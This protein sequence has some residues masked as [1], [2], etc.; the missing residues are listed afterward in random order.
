MKKTKRI[1]S[2]ALAAVLLAHSRQSSSLKT[3]GKYPSNR[4][5]KLFILT[6]KA[7]LEFFMAGRG[8]RPLSSA[9]KVTASFWV[10]A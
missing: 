9:K 8:H 4:R 7:C 5:S 2:A 1:L 10:F 6:N 3:H